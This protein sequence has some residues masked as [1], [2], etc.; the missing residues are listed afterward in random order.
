M[1]ILLFLFAKVRKNN[2]LPY[3][4]IGYW[5]IIEYMLCNGRLAKQ[6]A[7]R[8]LQIFVIFPPL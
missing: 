8:F 4:I 2:V 5:L 3:Q 1:E 7:L 6:E